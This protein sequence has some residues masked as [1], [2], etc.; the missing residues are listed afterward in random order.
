MSRP[1]G[2]KTGRPPPMMNHRRWCLE[3]RICSG[4]GSG[5]LPV[6]IF[7]VI[8]LVRADSLIGQTLLEALSSNPQYPNK[9]A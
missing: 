1:N 9:L 3:E 7:P 8:T 2:M 4:Y 6:V 5:R